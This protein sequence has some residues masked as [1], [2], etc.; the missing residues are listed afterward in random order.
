MHPGP[1]NRGVEVD[2]FAADG[3]H[4]SITAQVENG[5]FVRMASLYWCFQS[6]AKPQVTPEP[7]PQSEPIAAKDS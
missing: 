4:S 3:E 7:T 2:D 6:T 1:L 5:V